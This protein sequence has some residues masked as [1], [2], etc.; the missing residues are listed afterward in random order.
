MNSPA[1]NI[2]FDEQTKRVSLESSEK[3]SQ[4][5]STNKIQSTVSRSVEVPSHY[6]SDFGKN[7]TD[8]LLVECVK[9]GNKNAFDLLVIKYQA[10]IA[11]IV[12]SYLKEK[13]S[14][15]DVVQD[16]F[17]NAYRGLKGFRSESGFY[18]WIYRI[19]INTAINHIKSTKRKHNN[20]SIQD[21]ENIELDHLVAVNDE[22]TSTLNYKNL[23]AH[24]KTVLYELPI[25]MKTVWL[26]REEEG[27]KY[28][29]IADIVGCTVGTVKSRISRA[30]ERVSTEMSQFI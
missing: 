29:E 13:S 11:S 28:E 23:R 2:L 6:H 10:R 24:L 25:E 30:R 1:L 16:T 5:T 22:P 21:V 4:L 27:F 20:I 26:L 8:E 12:S 19:A 17:I 15:L 14:I 18:T 7:T 3:S 9:R